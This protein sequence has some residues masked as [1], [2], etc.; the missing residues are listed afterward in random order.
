MPSSTSSVQRAYRVRQWGSDPVWEEMPQ[1]EPGPGEALV[2]V[3]ACGVGLTVLNCINGDLGDDVGLLPRVPGHE[4]VG[5]VVAL[6]RAVDP[7]LEGRRVVA[8]FYLACDSC[9]SCWSGRQARCERLAGFVGVHRDGGYGPFAALPA[10]NV[11]PVPDDLDPVAATVVPDAVATPVHIA[12]RRARIRPSDR[13]AVIGA[14]GGVGAHMVQVAA[15]YG[16]RV[17]GMDVSDRKLATVERLG[18][19]PVDSS[20]F[21][22]VDAGGLWQAGPP[23]VIVD[24]VG[25]AASLEWAVA[26]I[27]PGGRVVVLTTFPGRT[28]RLSQRQ[29]VVAE[30]AVLGSRYASKAE[31]ETA[32]TMVASGRVHPII[33]QTTGP[34]D[35]LALHAALRAGALDGRGALIWR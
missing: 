3:E 33:G 10:G 9:R 27:A 25:T 15:L 16:A 32:A 5:R 28:G 17:V 24:L 30:G 18:A 23:T 2:R 22:G 34:A 26:G 21:D 29:L 19:R 35:V 7:Q 6:G 1:P 14:G 8:Y 12:Q 4:L 13:V 11:I 31:V 20:A